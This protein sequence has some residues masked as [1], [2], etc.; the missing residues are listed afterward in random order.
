MDNTNIAV[1]S[2]TFFIVW[3]VIAVF[4]IY[5]FWRIFEKAGQPG[6]ASIIPIYNVY[7]LIKIVKKPGWWLI[8][9]FIPLV[10][11]VIGIIV[12]LELAKV[13]GKDIG[14]GLGLL[15]LGFIFYPI[16]AFDNS[17]YIG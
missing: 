3:L 7:V 10:N 11:F 4:Y 5:A 16:L 8:L 1:F 17:K 15:F 12:T 14:F 2:G 13:F 6:W 9:M